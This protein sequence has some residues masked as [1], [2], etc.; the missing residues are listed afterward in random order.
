MIIEWTDKIYGNDSAKISIIGK[1][2]FLPCVQ[3]DEG[4]PIYFI[5]T[6]YIYIRKSDEDTIVVNDDTVFAD[7]G[8]KI[9][10]IMIGYEPMNEDSW[11]FVFSDV[12]GDIY[13]HWDEKK[14]Q[15][16]KWEY[17]EDELNEHNR[18]KMKAVEYNL[19][20]ME[21]NGEI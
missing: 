19:A 14:R 16:H 6:D 2:G 15:N 1:D 20:M 5:N 18:N 21:K 3:N 4:F 11:D 13:R 9:R 7:F 12:D 10:T 8:R 17:T